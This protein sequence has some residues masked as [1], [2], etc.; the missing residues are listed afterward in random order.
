MK[1]YGSV[2]VPSASHDISNAAQILCLLCARDGSEELLLK[3]KFEGMLPRLLDLVLWCQKGPE[4]AT[5]ANVYSEKYLLREMCLFLMAALCRGD[6]RTSDDAAKLAAGPLL[7][8]LEEAL[9]NVSVYILPNCSLL[10]YL[11]LRKGANW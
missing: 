7:G 9:Q 10:I 4:P 2:S 1:N 8:I 11:C 3:L 5:E 6:P